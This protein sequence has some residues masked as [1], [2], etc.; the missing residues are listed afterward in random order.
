MY[1]NQHDALFTTLVHVS[2]V[3]AAHHQEVEFTYV[4]N[5]TGYASKLTVSGLDK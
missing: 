2:G 4:A 5:G 1:N 3:S